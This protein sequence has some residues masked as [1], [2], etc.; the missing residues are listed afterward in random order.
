MK[1]PPPHPSPKTRASGCWLVAFTAILIAAGLTIIALFLPPFELADRLLGLQYSPLNA[2]APTLSFGSEL[3]I[4]LPPEERGSDFALKITQLSQTDFETNSGALPGWLRAARRDLPHHLRLT[5]PIF[6][7]DARGTAPSVLQ[8]E[9]AATLDGAAPG[10]LLLYGWDGVAWRFI[11]ARFSDSLQGSADFVPQALAAFQAIPAAPIVL[12][13]Q[14]VNQDLD[15]DI[16]KLATIL[17]PAGLR[18]TGQGSLLGSLA[19]GGSGDAAYL[20]LPVIRNF[21]HPRAIDTVSVAA[22]IADPALRAEHIMRITNI[23]AFNAFD[24]IFIDYRGLNAEHRANFSQFVSE[25]AASL[26]ARGLLLGAVMS[27][28]SAT[29]QTGGAAPLTIGASLA[30][31]LIISC[32]VPRPI[33]GISRPMPALELTICCAKPLSRS[34]APRSCSA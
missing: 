20:F 25:L 34:I 5:S 22:I 17:S 30:P 33:R 31:L 2:D 21:A 14:E 23:A 3:R 29:K 32:C 24:G 26:S 12:I 6:L 28:R 7:L 15:P 16:A 8:I 10:M 11:P 1:S 9:L 13:S 4:S 27:R 18:P 19:P